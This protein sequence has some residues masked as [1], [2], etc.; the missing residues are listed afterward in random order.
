M[1]GICNLIKK[2][3]M[4]FFLFVCLFFFK[5]LHH[6]GLKSTEKVKNEK[7]FWAFNPSMAGSRLRKLRSYEHRLLVME[8]EGRLRQRDQDQGGGRWEHN[9]PLPRAGHTGC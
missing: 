8:K 2:A 9:I 3:P 1:D 6:C 4:R 5:E 7:S